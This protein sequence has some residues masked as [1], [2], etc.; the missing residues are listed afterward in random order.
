[1]D[2]RDDQN[3]LVFNDFNC[4]NCEHYQCSKNKLIF[5]AF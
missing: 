2:T 5:K 3:I 1:M 4:I